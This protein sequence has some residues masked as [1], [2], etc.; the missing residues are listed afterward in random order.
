MPPGPSGSS[1][2]SWTGG[3]CRAAPWLRISS[4]SA[5]PGRSRRAAGFTSAFSRAL[6]SRFRLA[7]SIVPSP[8]S[9]GFAE[10][11]CVPLPELRQL[12]GDH[13]LAIALPRISDVVVVVVFLRWI[14]RP[15]RFDGRNDRIRV[16]PVP[17]ELCDHR[18]RNR[19][20]L[21]RVRE[22]GRAVL[23]SHVRA[24]TIRGGRI[25]G[26]EEDLQQLAIGDLVRV[27]GDA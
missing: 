5:S 14:E 24:L 4:S 3:T 22:D 8:A 26:A 2:S 9:G 17:L 27:E 21:G 19:P 13:Y 15:L 12:R 25:V 18:L 16:D 10:S 11:V 20:L 7:S 1:G 6:C 23:R